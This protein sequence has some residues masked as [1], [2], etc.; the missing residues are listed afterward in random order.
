MS[1]HHPTSTLVDPRAQ[2]A[3]RFAFNVALASA[4][5]YARLHH[6]PFNPVNVDAVITFEGED[7]AVEVKGVGQTSKT[8]T[9]AFTVTHRSTGFSFTFDTVIRSE[10]RN[11]AGNVKVRYNLT[12]K[13]S[14]TTLDEASAGLVALAAGWLAKFKGMA[15]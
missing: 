6:I 12:G 14:W 10:R 3:A 15:G 8:E 7:Y 9:L 11:K 1:I 5:S 4:H 13:G 2:Q